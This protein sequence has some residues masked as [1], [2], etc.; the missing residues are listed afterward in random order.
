MALS[1]VL[2]STSS[3]PTCYGEL[4]NDP[5]RITGYPNPT[6]ADIADRAVREVG[7]NEELATR[8][9]AQLRWMRVRLFLHIRSE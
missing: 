5:S 7:P 8:D 9:P 4:A 1:S 6:A 2:L 3:P